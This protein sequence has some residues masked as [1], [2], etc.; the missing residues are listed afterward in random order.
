M[1][2][3]QGWLGDDDCDAYV[4]MEFGRFFRY[5]YILVMYVYA[6]IHAFC[7]TRFF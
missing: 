3:F 2:L 7:I 6:V 1:G 5:V 4:M